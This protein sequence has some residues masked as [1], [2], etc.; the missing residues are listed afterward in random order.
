MN[1]LKRKNINV[2]ILVFQHQF[3]F[4]FE[5]LNR[6]GSSEMVKSALNHML[7]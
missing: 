3:R 4:L 6:I 1:V 2:N 5:F 7:G